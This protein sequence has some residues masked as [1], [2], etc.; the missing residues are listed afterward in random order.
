[1]ELYRECYANI[2][3][4]LSKLCLNKT[5]KDVLYQPK[6]VCSSMKCKP[7]LLELIVESKA[8]YLPEISPG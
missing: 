6:C 3:C 1:M 4:S 5:I 2:Y 8:D 7:P